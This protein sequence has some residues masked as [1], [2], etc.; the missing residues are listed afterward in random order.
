MTQDTRHAQG[1]LK[2]FGWNAAWGSILGVALLSGAG[3]WVEEEFVPAT[4]H[5]TPDSLHHHEDEADRMKGQDLLARALAEF[6]KVDEYRMEMRKKERLN[7]KLGAEQTVVVSV[8][9]KPFK[10]HMA[11]KE[12]KAL[13]GQEAVFCYHSN[14]QKMKGKS[15][16]FLGNIGFVTMNLDDPMARATSRHGIDEAG[17]QNLLSRLK[18]SWD[19]WDD[20]FETKVHVTECEIDGKTCT[21]VDVLQ[22]PESR[23]L[24]E[25]ARTIISFAADTGFPVRM[26]LY[27]WSETGDGAGELLESY[28]YGK[29][30][31]NPGLPEEFHK[32]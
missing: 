29:L 17:F 16:G 12:P 9:Q 7:G 3:I 22:D 14:P 10:V 30:E 20:E 31:L 4:H 6:A 26:E 2:G 21:T 15:A 8:R 25:F 28:Q 5:T 13:T 18:N 11:W 32:K 1:S 23:D 27:G 19:R 24:N